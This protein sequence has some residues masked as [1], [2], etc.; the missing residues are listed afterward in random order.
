MQTFFE[1]IDSGIQ[2][3]D[4]TVA[5]MVWLVQHSQHD[6]KLRP[7]ALSIIK[8]SA[9]GQLQ[10]VQAIQDWVNANVRYVPDPVTVETVQAPSVTVENSFGDCD[11]QAVLVA[12]LLMSI[13]TEVQFKAVGQGVN[14]MEHV[15]A[16]ALVGGQ[17]IDVDTVAYGLD[18][19]AEKIYN[20]KEVD[21]MNVAGYVDPSQVAQGNRREN[22]VK[23]FMLR[24]LESAWLDGL[25]TLESLVEMQLGLEQRRLPAYRSDPVLADM[26]VDAVKQ[27]K[28]NVIR[29]GIRPGYSFRSPLS[30]GGSR[31]S[32]LFEDIGTWV[33]DNV[34][35]VVKDIVTKP[36][37][38]MPQ[39]P[40][41][42]G[43]PGYVP[44][45]AGLLDQIL[46]NPLILIG[47]GALIVYLVTKK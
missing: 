46:G 45:G 20:V 32:G 18:Y 28:S 44:T 22:A 36:P 6:S 8:T 41:G 21:T 10:R 42:A 47:A 34:W 3:T 7:L 25:L 5:R 33:L 17:W 43:T 15:W 13:G 16:Q 26:L 38:Q 14:E 23:A 39:V 4:Q 11:D 12:A 19:R 35:P 31:L 30:L 40:T 37:Q 29:K 24:K 2:G 1:Q 9:D 27:F